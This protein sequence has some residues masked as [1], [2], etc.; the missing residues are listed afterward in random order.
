MKRPPV[1][2]LVLLA[3]VLGGCN[4]IKEKLAEKAAEKVVESTTGEDVDLSSSSGGATI[5][6]KKS[7]TKVTAGS[8]AR[9]PDDWPADVPPYPGAKLAGAFSSP[10]SMSITMQTDDDPPKVASFY[11]DKLR[12]M[13]NTA[14]LDLGAQQ[15]LTFD[16]SKRTVSVTVGAGNSATTIT[17][18]V[19]TRK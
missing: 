13:K 18:A 16:E 3:V 11:K 10:Q 8:A 6:D 19:A 14:T 15:V 5:T 2:A 9:L 17:I 4:K 12:G 1:V 7:G